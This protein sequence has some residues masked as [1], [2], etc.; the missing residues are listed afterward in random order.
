M[1]DQTPVHIAVIPDGNRRWAKQ[2]KLETAEG[3]KAGYDRLREIAEAC[4]D[5]G[6][7]YVTAYAFSTENWS[8]TKDEVGYLM[9]LALWV[10]ET[11][12]EEYH[13][14]NIRLRLIGSKQDLDQKLVEG[15]ERAEKLTAGNTAGTISLC[16][17]YGGRNDLIEAVNDL[18][19]EGA[20]KVDEESIARHLATG[21]MPEP[22]LIIR[23]SG[24]QRLS[25]FLIWEGAYSEL[26]FADCLW[27]D[28]DASELDKALDEYASRQRRYGA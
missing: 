26:Y 23:T 12:A 10:V 27:P 14:K 25:N 6:V 11:E 21:D 3:H 9:Q 5:R 20:D 16:F 22:D 24:E 17:N 15:I 28:F 4:F 18:I 19:K 8:R 13:K 1:A 7:K 2:H